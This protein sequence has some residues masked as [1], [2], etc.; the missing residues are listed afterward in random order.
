MALAWDRGRGWP[1]LTRF[2]TNAVADTASPARF[3]DAWNQTSKGQISEANPTDA[4]LAI[5]AARTSTEAAPVPVLNG[6]LPGR[7]RLN[8]LGFGR[9]IGLTNP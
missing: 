8:L 9:H 5:K 7:F 6:E 3:L 4:E 2:G 1:R